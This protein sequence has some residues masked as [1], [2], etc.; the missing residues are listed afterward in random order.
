MIEYDFV[1]IKKQ[2]PNSVCLDVNFFY[3]SSLF[4]IQESIA[5]SMQYFYFLTTQVP[6]PLEPVV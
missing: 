6:I 4:N 2:T 1:K 5:F 3:R